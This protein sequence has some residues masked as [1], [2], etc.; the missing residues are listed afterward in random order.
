VLREWIVS[1]FD[2]APSMAHNNSM[3][4]TAVTTELQEIADRAAKGLRD[5]QDMRKA[6]DEMNHTRE[7]LRKKIG[8][9]SVAVDLVREARDP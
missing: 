9:V 2:R 8:T 3:D 6:V 5:P 4:A 1:V 7:E